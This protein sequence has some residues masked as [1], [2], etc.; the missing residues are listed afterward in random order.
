[1]RVSDYIADFLSSKG[2][3]QVYLITSRGSLFLTD[4]IARNKDLEPI[5]HHEQAAAF[6]VLQ[7]LKFLK[8]SACMVS[9]GCASTNVLTAVLSTWQDGIPCIFV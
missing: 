1:M 6:A 8:P 9:T 3:E 7:I 4:G 5:V 2:I